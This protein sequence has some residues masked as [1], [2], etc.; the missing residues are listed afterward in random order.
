MGM[1]VY[2]AKS[3]LLRKKER[4][5]DSGCGADEK[6]INEALDVARLTMDNYMRIANIVGY[7]YANSDSHEAE[8]Y[9]K[10]IGKV[11][12]DDTNI[13]TIIEKDGD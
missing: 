6:E 11:L 9:M 8:F 4:K 12:E 7:Y 1:T 13:P 3:I 5:S 10:R 2:E